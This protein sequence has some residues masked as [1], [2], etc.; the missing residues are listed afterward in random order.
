MGLCGFLPS[1]ILPGPSV[2]PLGRADM[3]AQELYLF[4]SPRARE[5][6]PIV[7]AM[8]RDVEHRGVIVECLL[9]A[10]A[11]VNVL[12]RTSGGCFGYQSKL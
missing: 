10:V 6:V 9:G 4:R 8:Q 7:I 1:P 2:L 11:M 5:E 3:K 12:M